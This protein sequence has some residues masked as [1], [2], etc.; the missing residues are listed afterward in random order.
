MSLSTGSSAT[1]KVG[2][3][4]CFICLSL[5]I[6]DD[7]N[8]KPRRFNVLSLESGLPEVSD[9]NCAKNLKGTTSLE[10]GKVLNL[11]ISGANSSLLKITSNNLLALDQSLNY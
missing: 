8:S 6:Q 11:Q 1:R 5:C 4:E 3:H 9:N 7:P 10:L 2:P